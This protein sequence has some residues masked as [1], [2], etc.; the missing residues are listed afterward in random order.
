MSFVASESIKQEA[1]SECIKLSDYLLKTFRAR[2]DWT[3]NSIEKVEEMLDYLHQQA[4]KDKPTE[5]QVFAFAKGFGSYIGEVYRRN[6]G[7]DWGIVTL[8]DQQYPGLRTSSSGLE[9]WPWGRAQQ[10]IIEGSSNN[11]WHYYQ[12]LVASG[13]AKAE[14]PPKNLLPTAWWQR[15]LGRS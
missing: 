14:A 15:L 4:E 3:D 5:A 6:H 12:A 9:F 10:R 13:T 8:G 11:V 2:L 7:A 1:M